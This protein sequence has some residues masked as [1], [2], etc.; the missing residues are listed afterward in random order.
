MASEK[1]SRTD[2]HLVTLADLAPRREITGGIDRRVFA[3]NSVG[4]DEG[5]TA[6]ADPRIGVRFSRWRRTNR[7]GVDGRELIDVVECGET[8]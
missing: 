1:S 4:K 3:S 2:R 7:A 5:R 6:A 8:R